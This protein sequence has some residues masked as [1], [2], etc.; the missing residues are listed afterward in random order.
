MIQLLNLKGVFGGLSIDDETMHIM[1]FIGIYTLY[2]L[3]GVSQEALRLSLFLFS[4]R[5]EATLWL[6][7]LPQGSISRWNELRTQF[8]DKFFP[9]RILQLKDEIYNF[10]QLN[11]EKIY[12]TWLTFKKK[13]INV[14]NH[15]TLECNLLEIFYRALNIYTKDVVD[16][17]TSGAFLSLHWE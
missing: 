11:S 2:N 4:L 16:T 10:R 8:L 1:N 17:L 14:T 6:G 13:L 15:R 12:E 7:E 9:S 3:S 5:G